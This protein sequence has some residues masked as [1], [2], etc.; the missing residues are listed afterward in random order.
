MIHLFFYI[1]FQTEDSLQKAKG[2]L[3]NWNHTHENGITNGHNGHNGVPNGN[4][5]SGMK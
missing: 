2:I 1:F 3:K 4:G 5:M